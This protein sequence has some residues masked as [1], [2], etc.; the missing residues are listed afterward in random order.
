MKNAILGLNINSKEHKH[1][2]L[3]SYTPFESSIPSSFPTIA[4][5]L[6]R[7]MHV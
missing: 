4:N 1:D 5:L 3:A 7:G 6:E 2:L